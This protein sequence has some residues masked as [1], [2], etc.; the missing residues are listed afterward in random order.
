MITNDR[1][2]VNEFIEEHTECTLVRNAIGGFLVQHIRNGRVVTEFR[3][4][5]LKGTMLKDKHRLLLEGHIN[6]S[7]EV[8]DEHGSRRAYLG[9]PQ[10]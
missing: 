10:V 8:Y 2:E 7:E 3:V 6:E 9:V 5:I 4:E 1:Q